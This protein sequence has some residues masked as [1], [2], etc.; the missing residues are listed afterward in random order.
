LRSALTIVVAGV[1]LGA[2][3]GCG[4]RGD[5]KSA[6]IAAATTTL[7]QNAASSLELRGG[8]MFAGALTKTVLGRAGS[9]FPRALGFEAVDVPGFGAR[10]GG[11]VYLVFLPAAVYLSPSS[12][13][14]SVLPSGK[15]WVAAPI[16]PSLDVVFPHSVEQLEGMNPQLLLDELA[17]GTVRASGEGQV[18]VNH[19]PF[20]RYTVVVSLPRALAGAAGPGAGAMRLALQGQ[21]GALKARHLPTTV[22]LTVWLDGPGHV[23]QVRGAVPGSGLGAVQI[24]LSGFGNAIRPSLPAA[25]ALV[26]LTDLPRPASGVRLRSPLIALGIAP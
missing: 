24:A 3:A 1:L 13:A 18:V 16:S 15:T 9:L 17:W 2:V 14:Q 19:V 6:V 10:P 11:R 12:A 8:E 20:H 7:S 4:G 22:P 5:A 23:A 25:S 21:I 26:P